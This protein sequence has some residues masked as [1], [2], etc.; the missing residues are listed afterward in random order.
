M[1][2]HG[3]RALTLTQPWASLM[4]LQR[5]T[6]ETRSW[7]TDHRGELV[8][9]AAKGFPKWAREICEEEPF[10]SAL[11]GLRADDLPLSRGLCVVKVLACIRTTELHKVEAV[12]GQKPSVNEIEFGDYSEGRYA[13]VTEFVRLLQ[14][15]EPVKGEL[16]LWWWARNDQEKAENALLA[17]RARL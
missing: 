2:E 11:C 15:D 14:H 6:I 17:G 13:W 8:I 9:H 1:S 4:A 3:L 5:K 10:R 7:K 16:G 12:L